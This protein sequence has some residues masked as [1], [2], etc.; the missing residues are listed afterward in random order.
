MKEKISVVLP[1]YNRCKTINRA[2]SSVL[3][4]TYS[5][6]ELIIVDDA[7]TDATENVISNIHDSRIRYIKLDKNVGPSRAR[8]IGVDEAKSNYIAFMDSDDEWYSTKLERQMNYYL[9]NQQYGLVYCPYFYE[10]GRKIIQIPSKLIPKENLEGNI[11]YSLLDS[12]KIGTPTILIKKDIFLEFG[13]FDENL[14]CLEDWDFALKVAGKYKIGFVDDILMKA[15]LTSNGVN[16]NT[17]NAILGLI[18]IC[19]RYTEMDKS[20]IKKTIINLLIKNKIPSETLNYEIIKSKLLT[21]EE[22]D[23]YISLRSYNS[24]IEKYDIIKSLYNGCLGNVINNYISKR[25]RIVVYGAGDIGLFMYDWLK[26]EGYNVCGIM[27]RNKVEIK[28]IKIYE[29]LDEIENLDTIFST[30]KSITQVLNYKTLNLYNFI[31]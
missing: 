4:Q 12:N 17:K 28:N 10:N 5:E 16:S 24:E 1:T 19:A 9:K 13:G 15:Y 8:N 21:E 22:L 14:N 30:V 7:S 20:K 25:E 2:V 18:K 29:S 11:Y 3:N 31:D 26:K 27:D 6:I 23:A